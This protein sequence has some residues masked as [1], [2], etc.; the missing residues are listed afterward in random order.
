MAAAN[1]ISMDAAVAAVLSDLNGIVK[2]E[3]EQKN[4]NWGLF[5]EDYM[6]TRV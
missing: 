5:S 4:N 1:E 6:F 3:E 2:S